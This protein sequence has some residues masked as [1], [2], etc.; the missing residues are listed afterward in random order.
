MKIYFHFIPYNLKSI[1]KLITLVE[2]TN[3]IKY[4]RSYITSQ[5]F[6]ININEFT[7]NNY[8]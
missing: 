5:L 8:S 4:I 1:I 3:V 7:N 6:K 2:E